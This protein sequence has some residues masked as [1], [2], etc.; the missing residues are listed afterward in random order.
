MNVIHRDIKPE[1]FLLSDPS[2][3]ARLKVTDFGCSVFF[4]DGQ[5]FEDLVGS[6]YYIA[7]EVLRNQ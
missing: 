7:P 1:N 3:D 5:T 2:P 6:A 4:R